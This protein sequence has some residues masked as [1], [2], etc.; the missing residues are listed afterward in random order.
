MSSLL[1][2]GIEV[3]VGTIAGKRVM[4]LGGETDEWRVPPCPVYARLLLVDAETE[5]VVVAH[6]RDG[7]PVKQHRFAGE[8][9]ALEYIAQSYECDVLV[10]TRDALD[11][12]LGGQVDDYPQSP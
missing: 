6:R 11:Q 7:W 12:F 10:D 5:Q 1:P 3:Q 4:S 9:E 2:L 8:M